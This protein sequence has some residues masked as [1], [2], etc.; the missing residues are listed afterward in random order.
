MNKMMK[1]SVIT[2]LLCVIVFFLAGLLWGDGVLGRFEEYVSEENPPKRIF[3]FND[4]DAVKD[5]IN[6]CKINDNHIVKSQ[7]E[8]Y[9]TPY[10][11][12]DL[13]YPG[14]PYAK[15][16]EIEGNQIKIKSYQADGLMTTS[17][18]DLSGIPEKLYGS[19][20]QQPLRHAPSR[21]L[22]SNSA[23]FWSGLLLM[24]AQ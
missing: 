1:K 13:Y 23:M 11:F 18:L 10:F 14:I 12:F 19:E 7:V 17:I 8:K 22:I 20:F 6:N 21:I 24:H 2:I 5:I 4:Y 9:R 3:Y 16:T 15:G